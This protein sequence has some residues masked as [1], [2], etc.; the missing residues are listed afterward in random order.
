MTG[1]GEE[2]NRT[3][4]DGL[5]S[6]ITSIPGP[7]SLEL[8]GR[9]K[10]VESPD[11]T[12]FSK[13][14]PVFWDSASGANV[15]DVDGNRYLDLNAGFGVAAIGHSHPR[16]IQTVTRQAEVLIQGMGDVHP[17]ELR[18]DLAE[19][20]LE[21]SGFGNDGKV[22]FGMSG[23]ESVEAALKTAALFTG[24]PG[25]IAFENSYHGLSLGTL[26]VTHWSK[27]REGLEG[28]TAGEASYFPFPEKDAEQA[29]GV[30][31]EIET[32]LEGDGVQS[33]G[34]ILV[35]PIQGRGGIWTPPKGFLEGLRKICD[36]H[37]LVLIFDEIY[38]GIGRT[39]KWF[40]WMHER[41]RPDLLV[42]GKALGGGLPISVC[43]GRTAVI[44]AWGESGGEARHT[45]TFLGHPL[46]CSSAVETLAILEDENLIERAR[47][48]G[49]SLIFTPTPTAP[50]P[51][52]SAMPKMPIWR[53]GPLLPENTTPSKLPPAGL[54]I[55]PVMSSSTK[56]EAL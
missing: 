39:G 49:K 37:G 48:S 17:T 35:E 38:T 54:N 50:K 21:I 41:V 43:I 34:T 20:L 15:V 12:Y 36:R 55:V 5:P 31:D 7:R 4:Y 42:A 11:T 40:A 1:V 19:K 10:K 28:L 14:F 18:L 56:F 13:D 9:L 44:D 23:S 30:L 16:L 27:F 26:S 53:S 51:L 3:V 45:F 29:T 33:V 8:A 25:V 24:K 6:I 46:A 22:I 2:K 47:E 52:L 32:Y